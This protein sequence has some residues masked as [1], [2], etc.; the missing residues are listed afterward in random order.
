MNHSTTL[1]PLLAVGCILGALQAFIP[2]Y[3]T[4]PAPDPATGVISAEDR[5]LAAARFET[6]CSTCHGLDGKGHGPASMS[7]NPAPADWTDPDWQDSVD[8]EFLE[9]VIAAGGEAVGI[10]SLM[11]AS[12]YADRPGVMKA[13]VEIVR[14]HGR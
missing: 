11:P 2:S 5:A 8:D 7:L 14:G 12:P 9:I 3:T 1:R 4:A 6:H 13:L 10:S